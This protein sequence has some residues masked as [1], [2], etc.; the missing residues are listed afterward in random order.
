MTLMYIFIC[1]GVTETQNIIHELFKTCN[2]SVK[3][4]LVGNIRI[5]QIKCWQY[6]NKWAV[7]GLIVKTMMFIYIYIG[8][9]DTEKK[10]DSQNYRKL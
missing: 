9:G 3:V 8:N 4:N 2:E 5:C 6:L 10:T 1:N 7:V